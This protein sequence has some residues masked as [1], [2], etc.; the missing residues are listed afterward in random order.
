[1]EI[2]LATLQDADVDSLCSLQ[3]HNLRAN[4]SLQE[5]QRGGYLSIAFSVDEFA[6][7]NRD[8][9]VLVARMKHEVVAYCCI[10]SAGFNAKLPIL[11]QIV[12]RIEGYSV[13]GASKLPTL[14]TSCIWGPVCIAEP[15]RGNEILQKLFTYAGS[16]SKQAGYD[17]CFSF[18]STGN[19]RSLKAHLK[20]PF[21]EIDKVSH[22]DNEFDVI[23]CQLPDK[24]I[25]IV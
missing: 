9:G 18:V 17:F 12:K 15:W 11:E 23:G 8:L 5:Q 14:A 24:G 19:P 1:M 10:S 25:G 2:T 13:P 22:N 16:I 21:R 4:L 7:F 20:L 3:E 6:A